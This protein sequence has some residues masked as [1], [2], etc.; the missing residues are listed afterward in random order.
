MD[1]VSMAVI[2]SAGSKAFDFAMNERNNS[3]QRKEAR[4]LRNWQDRMS[5]T[6][7][8]REVADLRAAGLN[9]L[10]SLGGSGASTPA[11]AS[12]DYNASSVGDLG[13]VVSSARQASAAVDNT[14][15][16]TKLKKENVGV[17][18][19]QKALNSASTAKTIEDAKKSHQESENA[20]R[21]GD[22]LEMEKQKKRID[23]DFYERN[24]NWLPAA[25]AITPLV[26]QGVGTA[27]NALSL[28][29]IFNHAKSFLGGKKTTINSETTPYTRTEADFSN[30]NGRWHN[31]PDG[32]RK[33]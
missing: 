14:K 15:Q 18:A 17:S 4:S 26:G 30:S 12:A 22:I 8:Q 13:A 5:S 33:Y 29:S 7:H 10:L 24:K 2:A 32:D 16:D 1:P 31:T 9:P 6:A 20:R 21:T 28:G 19:T 27:V 3:F 11:G 25:N 23:T